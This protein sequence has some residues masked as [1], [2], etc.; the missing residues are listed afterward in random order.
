M[1]A[2]HFEGRPITPQDGQ[3]VVTV[4]ELMTASGQWNLQLIRDCF[5]RIDAEAIVRQ[6]V[7]CGE[8]DF[9]AWDLE[10]S[11][12]YSVKTAYKR[13][14]KNKIE[15]AQLQAP[16]SSSDGLWKV[17][18]KIEVPPKVRVFWWRVVHGFLPAKGV[19][20]RKHIE[21]VPFCEDCGDQRNPFTV[22]YSG[23][24]WP[25]CF[26]AKSGWGQE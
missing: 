17:L 12:V 9:W 16:S 6:P 18:W 7:G 2:N 13:L 8:H 15:G 3:N 10:N 24:R 25:R 20:F 5:L 21:P 4:T 14:Y 26:G 19:L 1:D 11:G 22:C 23:V